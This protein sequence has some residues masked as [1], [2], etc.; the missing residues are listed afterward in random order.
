[1]RQWVDSLDRRITKA[2][3]CTNLEAGDSGVIALYETQVKRFGYLSSSYLE[4]ETEESK[5]F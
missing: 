2:T 3:R 4:A 5:T 1:M